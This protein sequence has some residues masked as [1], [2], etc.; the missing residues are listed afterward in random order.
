MLFNPDSKKYLVKASIFFFFIMSIAPH[1]LS[2]ILP[3]S[4]IFLTF[5]EIYEV[6]IGSETHAC[7]EAAPQHA[8][9][10]AQHAGDLSNPPQHAQDSPDAARTDAVH[11]S[12]VLCGGSE[13]YLA[14]VERAFHDAVCVV[15]TLIRNPV[16]IFVFVLFFLFLF[17]VL[18]CFVF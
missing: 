2:F 6:S 8:K 14:E 1:L 16:R 13:M 15:L 3:L 11:G 17:F 12:V 5:W 4:S 18:F 7:I 10:A 9:N